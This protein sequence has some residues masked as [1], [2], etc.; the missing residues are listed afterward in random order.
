M[1]HYVMFEILKTSKLGF[2]LLLH[3]CFKCR[4]ISLLFLQGMY[5]NVI[6]IKF[7]IAR[8]LQYIE[9]ISA[10]V[11]SACNKFINAVTPFVF[12]EERKCVGTCYIGNKRFITTNEYISNYKKLSNH[13]KKGKKCKKGSGSG[14]GSSIFVLLVN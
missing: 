13:H 11:C 12:L 6:G 5:M 8:R 2:M 9:E 10:S 4:C 3:F 1:S 14:Q 7:V